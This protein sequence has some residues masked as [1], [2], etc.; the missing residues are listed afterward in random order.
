[1][2]R[3]KRVVKKKINIINEYKKSWKYLKDS[4]KFIYWIIGIFFFFFL[5]GIFIPAPTFLYNQIMDFI[6]KLLAETNGLSQFPL[7]SY[8]LFNN[9]KSTFFVIL[10]GTFF[11]IFPII[12][13]IANGY[14][15][16]FVSLLSIQNGG[17]LTLWRLF[18]HGIFEMPAVFI[19]LGLGLKLGFFPFQKDKLK[20]LKNNLISSLKVFIL[21]VVPLLLIAGIIE[22]T[23]MIFVK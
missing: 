2:S 6:K 1:M 16:G 5:V 23:L 11:G 13:A 15:L 12:S 8:I 17:I 10:L 14:V 18:P 7:I 4:K 20:S 3:K 21:I 22:G 19:S 9:L